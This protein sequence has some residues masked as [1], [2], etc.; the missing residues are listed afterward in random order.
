VNWDDIA[1][2]DDGSNFIF[3]NHTTGATPGLELKS[4]G[5]MVAHQTMP[6]STSNKGLSISWILLDNQPTCDIFANPELLTNI[7][8]VKGY[9]QL[10]KQAGSTTTNLA[11]DLPGYGAVWFHP[12]D[13]AHIIALTNMKKNHC[14][15]YDS[16]AGN[17][18]RVHKPDGTARIFKE[19]ANGLFFF[20]TT[21]LGP[22]YVAL[23][24]TVEKNKS[25]FTS[26]DYT[27]AQLAR[28]IQVLVGRPEL[29][30][31]I[32]Y[33]YNNMLPNCPINRNDAIA[34]HQM[35]GR[36]VGSLKGKT[37]RQKVAHVQSTHPLS[38]KLTIANKYRMV[39]LCINNMFVNQIGFFMSISRDIHFIWALRSHSTY[40]YQMYRS[41]VPGIPPTWF[42]NQQGPRGYGIR[43][44][45]RIHHRRQPPCNPP[46]YGQQR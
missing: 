38:L 8:R 28:K 23:V 2:Q 37:T 16:H 11:G 30:D 9:M 43:V 27:R 18:F 4:D 42:Q 26:R 44:L 21:S 12:N 39:T 33:L 17:K 6:F 19:S 20:D 14:I 45:P 31:S 7:C 41:N 40:P 15:T 3:L 36:N 24:T 25:R 22:K 32:A 35:F 46:Q 29:Q 13:I 10:S 1:T 5:T 34:A